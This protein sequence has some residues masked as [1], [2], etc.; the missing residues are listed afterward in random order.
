MSDG[1]DLNATPSFRFLALTSRVGVDVSGYYIGNLHFG[2]KVEGDFYA[3]LS[4]ASKTDEAS[5][6][7]PSN[8]KIG[9]TA[10][11]RLRQAYVTPHGRIFL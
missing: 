8:S 6:Y 1:V 4:A 11:A 7:F 10:Q 2:A 5:A 3:G 9:G